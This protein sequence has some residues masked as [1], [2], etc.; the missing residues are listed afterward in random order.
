MTAE[1]VTVTRPQHVATSA[2][3]P[4]T[5]LKALTAD[6]PQDNDLSLLDLLLSWLACSPTPRPASAKP[7]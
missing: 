4:K 1:P 6:T 3:A 5:Q 2:P 7:C